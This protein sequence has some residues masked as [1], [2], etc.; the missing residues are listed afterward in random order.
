[1]LKLE[2]IYTNRYFET[3]PSWQIIYEWEDVISKELALDLIDARSASVVGKIP[4]KILRLLSRKLFRTSN[5]ILPLLDRL[6]HK[7]TALYY[8]LLARETFYFTGSK[9]TVPV[10]VDFWKFTDLDGFY[11]AYKNCKAVLISSI[12]V[13]NYLK[14]NNC[15]LNIFHWPLSLPD[16]YRLN[17][18]STGRREFDIVIPGR[19]NEVLWDYLKTYEKEFPD[20]EYIY[21][22]A[23]NGE[24]CYVSNHR[25]VIGTFQDRDAYMQ[26]L[27]RC[28]TSFYSTPGIDGDEKRTGGFS[29]VTPRFL[30][31]ISAG[32]RIIAR[33]PD[34]DETRFYHME[35]IC[36][37]CNDY[38]TF[39]K[40]LSGALNSSC[41]LPAL[42]GAYLKKHYTSATV[43]QLTA[44]LNQIN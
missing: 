27:R 34:N 7:K 1:M 38:P 31:M 24:L 43:T 2:A 5:R 29:P 42:Y 35:Q 12:E 11:Q 3:W 6:I 39:R 16:K 32:C 8:E 25:G 14:R 18:T 17:E 21:R 36:L 10:I 33:Y 30:E 22:E 23:I 4:D 20:I 41:D 9:N 19:G 13:Y 28:K 37:S 26:L 15:P 44:I 40:E